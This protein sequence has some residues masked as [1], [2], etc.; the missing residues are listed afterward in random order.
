MYTRASG[1]CVY[2]KK[3]QVT[4]GMFR[5]ISR[6][7]IAYFLTTPP[8]AYVIGEFTEISWK[9]QKSLGILKTSEML[10][11]HFWEDIILEDFQKI[12]RIFQGNFF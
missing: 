7:S 11:N 3:M 9:V 10:Q 6:E 5:G 4:S 12:F 2:M 1:V 8:H